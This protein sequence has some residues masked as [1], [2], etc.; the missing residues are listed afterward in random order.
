[1][2]KSVSI[3]MSAV[4]AYGLVAVTPV[5]SQAQAAEQTEE[6]SKKRVRRAQTLRP[7]IFKKLDAVRA[8]ADEKKY[9]EALDD[10]A[11]VEK[12]RRNSYEQ[13]MTHNM[14]AYVYFNKEDYAGAI[15][16]Y[17]NVLAVDNIPESLEQTTLYSLAKLYLMQENY[18]ESLTTLNK[19]FTVV[20]KPGAE[21]FIL[22]AQMQFQLEQYSKALPDVKKAIAMVKEQG[23]KPKENWLMLERAVYY[24]NKDFKN[25]ARCLQDLATLYPKGQYW[26]QLAAVYSE[27]GQPLKELT[28]LENA[29]DQNMLTREGELMNLAYALMGQEIP[30]KAAKVLE[31]GLKDEV[32]K[33]TAKNLS[34][35]GDAWMLAKEYDKAIVV[36]AQAAK[37]S[38]A[39]D[40]FF[41]L[42]QIHTE[43]QEWKLALDN[44]NA[45]ISAGDLKKTSAAYILKGNILFNLDD[46]GYAHDMFAKAKDYP[47]AEKMA[48]QWIKYI[49]GE[50]KRREYMASA[51]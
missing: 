1:M 9:D 29:Y 32:I 36:M 41:K 50:Q 48:D 37:A 35:L 6:A 20:E 11:S 30:F 7:V 2:N 21:A 38:G 8:L 15:G 25:L 28:A 49:D 51:G 23:N 14:Y 39:G 13:A 4:L 27:L 34:T 3:L 43:R 26:V 44:V 16:A 40:D 19:W 31:K 24:Q 33:P 12:V 45:A 46:L 22:R 17:N 47:E 5:V 10:L 42:A 18:K